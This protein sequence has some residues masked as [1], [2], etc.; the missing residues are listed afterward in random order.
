MDTVMSKGYCMVELT[1]NGNCYWFM[2]IHAFEY[3]L[4]I[5]VYDS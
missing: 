4:W 5:K 3:T 2:I 1:G